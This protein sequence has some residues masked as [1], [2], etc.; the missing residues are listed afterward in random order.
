MS[1]PAV[2]AISLDKKFTGASVIDGK[3]PISFMVGFF[4][5]MSGLNASWATVAVVGFEAILVAMD[6]GMSAA[7]EKRSPQSY[8]NQMVDVMVGIA[9]VYYGEL[10]KKNQEQKGYV[11]PLPASPIAQQQSGGGIS[12]ELIAASNQLPAAS[13]VSGVRW[14]R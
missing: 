6:E 9:G 5:G 7:F 14:Y 12:P 10:Y 8:G 11:P 3:T 4:A 2:P 13:E 1:S